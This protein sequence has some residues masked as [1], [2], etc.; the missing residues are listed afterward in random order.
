MW[1]WINHSDRRA[2]CGRGVDGEKIGKVIVLSAQTSLV[3]KA[4]GIHRP[5][6]MLGSTQEYW[7]I[8]RVYICGVHD[9]L[10]LAPKPNQF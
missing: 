1:E 8:G 3:L 10:S 9:A 6:E 2:N 7:S 5:F 4:S